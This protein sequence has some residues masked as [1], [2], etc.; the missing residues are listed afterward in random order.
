MHK[1]CEGAS[2]EKE[3]C[4]NEENL[5]RSYL[6]CREDICIKYG[7]LE[8]HI[9]PGTNNVDLCRSHHMSKGVCAPAPKLEGNIFVD[10]SDHICHYSN[11]EFN[12][13]ECAFHKDGKAICKPGDLDME[14]EWYDL[15]DYLNMEPD[16]NPYLSHLSMCDYAEEKVGRRYLKAAIDYYKLHYF[17]YTQENADCVKRYNHPEYFNYI[18]RYD[19]ATAVST[20]LGLLITIIALL[21]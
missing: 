21:I 20:L 2:S 3:F 11:G 18:Q 15:L 14:T 1:T 8:N 10:N 4:D 17:I 7:S 5:C 12:K 13:A 6:Y 19:G 9:N 16:C